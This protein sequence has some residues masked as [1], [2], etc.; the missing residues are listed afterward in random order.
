VVL[1]G[2]WH[3]VTQR[4]NRRQSIF[5]EDADRHFYLQLLGRHCSKHGVAITGY[6]LM[7]NHV[8][9]I[10]SPTRETSLARAFGQAH[11]DY[12][13]W[14]NLRRGETGHFWQNRYFSCPLDAEHQWA[15]L[16]YV[17]LNP[18]RAGMV[19]WAWSSAAAHLGGRDISGFVNLTEWRDRWRPET[20]ADALAEGLTDAATARENS[21]GD[22]DRPSSRQRRFREASGE[23]IESPATT[24]AARTEVKTGGIARSNG[25]GSLVD[26]HR[27]TRIFTSC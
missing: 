25:P 15:A 4:G 2:V 14:L 10:A 16:R 27:I 21:G 3:H 18:V 13:R 9:V 6:C 12:A 22:P 1:P 11:T 7:T 5:F 20:W 17:E 26:C 24:D 19:E 8:H 23:A